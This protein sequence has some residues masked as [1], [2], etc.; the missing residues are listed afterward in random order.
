MIRNIIRDHTYKHGI[1]SDRVHQIV[2]RSIENITKSEL[3]YLLR[4]NKF[5]EVVIEISIELL[6]AEKLEIYPFDNSPN[7]DEQ[8]ELIRELI[9]VND[10]YWNLNPKGF[11]RFRD[12]IVDKINIVRLPKHSISHF[13]NY[14]PELIIWNEKD[15]EWYKDM[16]AGNS[17]STVLTAFEKIRKISRSIIIGNKLI[18]KLNNNTIEIKDIIEF[19]NVVVKKLPMYKELIEFMSSEIEYK[20]KR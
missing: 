3:A 6:T 4:E 5:I 19:E 20:T 14:Q 9:L 17:A 13:L 12:L 10:E 16:I 2:F 15:E 8:R 1:S 18:V 7:S 11:Q